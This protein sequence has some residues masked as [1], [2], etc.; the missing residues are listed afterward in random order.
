MFCLLLITFV[1]SDENGIYPR[2]IELKQTQTLNHALN[3]NHTFLPITDF[4]DSMS[5]DT[6]GK[7]IS[8]ILF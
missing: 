1:I 3:E 2:M 8:L 6:C 5:Q 7:L 4:D